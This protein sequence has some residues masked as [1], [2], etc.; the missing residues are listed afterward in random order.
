MRNPFVVLQELLAGPPLQVA[1]V[2]SSSAGVSIV[3]LPGGGTL[4]VRGTGTAGDN[5]F[6]RGD[7]IEG[8]APSLSVVTI[9]V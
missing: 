4:Q 3:E 2:V 9:E 7:L 5:V 8:A 6:I 1:T